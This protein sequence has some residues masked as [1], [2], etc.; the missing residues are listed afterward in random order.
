VFD[1]FPGDPTLAGF[2]VPRLDYDEGDFGLGISESAVDRFINENAAEFELDEG[3]TL[4]A[5]TASDFEINE[6]VDA[7]YLMSRA[8]A[9]PLRVVYGVRYEATD[10]DASGFRVV[11]DEVTGDGDPMLSPV[12]FEDDYDNWLPSVNVRYELRQDLLLRAAWY[13]TIARPTFGDLAP[14]GEIEFEEDDGETELEAE[15]GNP[16]LEPLEA[17]NFDLSLEHYRQG[18]GLLSAGVFYKALDNFVVLAD[19]AEL[20]DLSQFVGATPVDDAEVIQPINGDQAEVLG[21]EVA[22]VQKL[23]GL[24]GPLAN[25]LVSANATFTDS[26]AELALRPG[27]IDL[28]RQS[29]RVYN[30]ALGYETDRVSA[31]LAVTSKSEALIALEE[32]GDPAFDVYQDEHT[33]LDFS[34]KY[35]VTDAWQVY[36]DAINLTDEPFYAFFDQQRFNAQFETYGRTFGLGVQYQ[37]Q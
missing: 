19:T 4:A 9:G 17:R 35:D 18:L 36:F 1:G 13:D 32:P 16:A 28:P 29:D 5:S 31:R 15:I 23:T 8:D 14:G 34:V 25:L 26:E 24:P 2:E 22:W 27:K 30:V 10:F 20:I 11:F 21:L 7:F 37:P 33:Q 6:D 12:T 3:D